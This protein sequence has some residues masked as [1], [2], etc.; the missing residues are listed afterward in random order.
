MRPL[1]EVQYTLKLKFARTFVDIAL[2]TENKQ[3]L[4]EVAYKTQDLRT[5]AL[6]R[7]NGLIK[8]A[9]SIREGR[10]ISADSLCIAQGLQRALIDADMWKDIKR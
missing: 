5:W 2:A 7:I 4:L 1:W 3:G 8:E 9:V 10:N 6:A